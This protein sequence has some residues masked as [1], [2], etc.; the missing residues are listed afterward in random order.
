MATAVCQC[1]RFGALPGIPR[2]IVL[3]QVRDDQQLL[4]LL[5]VQ[6][7]PNHLHGGLQLV[8]RYKPITIPIEY[9]ADGERGDVLVGTGDI[10]T[11]NTVYLNAAIK[12]SVTSSASSTGLLSLLSSCDCWSSRSAWILPTHCRN[13]ASLIKPLPVD[14]RI[15]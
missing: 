14:W 5:L 2:R 10:N 12:S 6:G 15:R 9:S 7:L 11:I 1:S 4:Q 3:I 8:A 13:S